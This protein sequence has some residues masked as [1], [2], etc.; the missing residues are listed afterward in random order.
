MIRTT[1]SNF[2][3]LAEDDKWEEVLKL[4]VML[5]VLFLNYTSVVFCIAI[6]IQMRMH[7]T[8]ICLQWTS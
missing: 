7:R 1:W 3:L 2:D 5:V 6:I 8:S 4:A